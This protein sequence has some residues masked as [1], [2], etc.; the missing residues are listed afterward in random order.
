MSVDSMRVDPAISW[1]ISR[2]EKPKPVEAPSTTAKVQALAYCRFPTLNIHD[3]QM[4]LAFCSAGALWIARSDGERFSTP[5]KLTDSCSEVSRPVISPDNKKIAYSSRITTIFETAVLGHKAPKQLTFHGGNSYPVKYL[6]DHSLIYA[7]NVQSS[8]SRIYQLYIHTNDKT[9]QIALSSAWEIA[10]SEDKK[11]IFFTKHWRNDPA[12]RYQAGSVKTIWSYSEGDTTCKPLTDHLKGH[13]YNPMFWQ[14]KVYFLRH[15]EGVTNIFS[16]DIDGGNI[17]QNTFVENYDIQEASLSNGVIAYRQGVQ[18]YLY[19]CD[20]GKSKAAEFVLTD[21]A[22]LKRDRWIDNPG[23]YITDVHPSSGGKTMLITCRGQLFLANTDQKKPVLSLTG[24]SDIRYQQAKFIGQKEDIIAISDKDG[25]HAFWKI[26]GDKKVKI[27]SSIKARVMHYT[28]SPCGQYIFCKLW[29][30]RCEVIDTRTKESK[31]L[32]LDGTR[33]VFSP[34]SKKIAIQVENQKNRMSVIY[35][36]DL[37]TKELTPVTSDQR[38][39]YLPRWSDDNQHLLFVSD[40]H[41]N[42]SVTSGW[43][44]YGQ[45][46]HFTKMGQICHI[47]LTRPFTS[48][49]DTTETPGQWDLDGVFSRIEVISKEPQKIKNIFLTKD[50]VYALFDQSLQVLERANKANGWKEIYSDVKKADLTE[51]KKH[52]LILDKDGKYH[53]VPANGKKEDKESIPLNGWKIKVSPELEWRQRFDEAWRNQRDLFYDQN[54][55]NIDWDA[56]RLKY[57]PFLASVTSNEELKDLIAQMLGDL[58]ALHHYVRDGDSKKSEPETNQGHLGAVFEKCKEGFKI[59]RIL[60]TDPD[61]TPM[62]SPLQTFDQ[63]FQVGDII[64]KI[65]GKSWDSIEEALIE[66][67]GKIVTL[68]LADGKTHE[69]ETHDRL[70]EEKLLHG[71]WVFQNRQKVARLSQNQIGYVQME[72]MGE[73]GLNDFCRQFFPQN[74]KRGMILD[75]RRNFGGNVDHLILEKLLKKRWMQLKDSHGVAANMM[76]DAFDGP[77]IALCDETSYSDAETFLLAFQK[78]KLGRVVGSKTWGGGIWLDTRLGRGIDHGLA[79]IPNYGCYDMEGT[80]IIEGKGIEP[81][82]VVRNDPR[83]EF[84]GHDDILERGVQELLNQVQ[85]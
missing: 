1:L 77:L 34:D 20:S 67:K 76:V 70:K 48:L 39:S 71:E 38:N 46:A 62:R 27:S 78:M 9:E 57:Q 53:I 52:I 8:F 60:N 59:K 2:N 25:E 22:E 17:T 30:K 14:Q 18:I 80:Q 4:L 68:T 32:P 26:S 69:V 84:D 45:G 7:S 73:D 11:T 64:T 16:M 66:M 85:K 74:D 56:V 50:H 75:L 82:I 10:F 35:I 12:K 19:F 40:R 79:S 28:V 41:F 42:S 31:S 13:C 5:Q 29:R 37:V 54:M 83:R 65:N 21:D 58:G 43:E 47:P 72:D 24:S 6:P 49:F 3:G 63:K 23:E 36:Y 15:S 55:H 51:N 44:L 81:D 33:A 61:D